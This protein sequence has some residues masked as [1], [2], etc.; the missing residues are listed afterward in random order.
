MLS[1][2]GRPKCPDFG[3]RHSPSW[4]LGRLYRRSQRLTAKKTVATTITWRLAMRRTLRFALIWRV[5]VE[6]VVVVSRIANSELQHLTSHSLFINTYIY[7]TQQHTHIKCAHLARVLTPGELA[8]CLFR[9]NDGYK[10]YGIFI[11]A[12]EIN[13]KFVLLYEYTIMFKYVCTA[14]R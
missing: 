9:I 3:C 6:F 14:I 1:C 8:S 7:S 12:T 11:S 5:I 10:H 4:E 13:W 2:T